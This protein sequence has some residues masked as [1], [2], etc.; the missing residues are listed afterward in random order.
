MSPSEFLQLPSYVAALI[1]VMFS[2]AILAAAEFIAAL[3]RD[4]VREKR[5]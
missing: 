2:P 1:V 4:L 5:V 3:F